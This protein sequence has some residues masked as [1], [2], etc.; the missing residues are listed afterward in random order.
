MNCLYCMRKRP[1]CQVKN[2]SQSGRKFIYYFGN[3]LNGKIRKKKVKWKA[4]CKKCREKLTNCM[5]LSD[6]IKHLRIFCLC[7]TINKT[8]ICKRSEKRGKT[9]LE[10]T[11]A[12]R[13]SGAHGYLQRF[14]RMRQLPFPRKAARGFF[15]VSPA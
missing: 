14:A 6:F 3:V 12:A 13:G 8:T 9:E 5:L 15:C 10:T 2:N 11:F 1:A 7:C 4:A